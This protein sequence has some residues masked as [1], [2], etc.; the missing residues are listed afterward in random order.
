M[1]IRDRLNGA[2]L[3]PK[4]GVTNVHVTIP[5]PELNPMD[6]IVD[7][8]LLLSVNI[9][10]VTG[11]RPFGATTISTSCKEVPLKLTP[12]I[13]PEVSSIPVVGFTTTKSGIDV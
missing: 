1:C 13:A 12:I 3:N 10:W 9:W 2:V 5:T 7:P 8:L 6:F 4:I 11:S